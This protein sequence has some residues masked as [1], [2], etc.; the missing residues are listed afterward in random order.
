[1]R[2]HNRKILVV[3]AGTRPAPPDAPPGNGRAISVEAAADGA[4]VACLDRD[5]DS[6]EETVSLI[7]GEH[8]HLAV[9]I[10]ADIADPQACQD[11]V[12]EAATALGGL[13]GLVLNV[14]VALGTGLYDTTPED[15]DTTFTVNVR[16]QYLLA[17]AAL[18]IFPAAGASIVVIGS[19]A[20]SRGYAWMPAY[21]ASKLAL[22]SLSRSIAAEGAPGTRCNVVSPGYIDTPLQRAVD[23]ARAD[24]A[25]SS[26]RI[27]LARPGTAWD[28]AKAVTFLLSDDAGY[29]TGQ[30][31]R[32]DGGLTTLG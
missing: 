7:D 27:P 32:V 14:G 13:D 1:V 3:G 25:R 19:V 22:Q 29:I 4:A 23:I 2:L 31:L 11:A 21:E 17:R 20:G 5:K 18:D 15:W 10:V 28:V 24:L 16:A 8:G 26:P 12:Q 30:E 6:V 9:S